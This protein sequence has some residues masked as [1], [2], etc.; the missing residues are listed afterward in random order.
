MCQGD[1]TIITMMFANYSLRPIGNF[2]SP[3][4][5][6]NWPRLLEWVNPNS[7]DLTK[8]GWLMHP[9]YGKAVSLTI[10]LFW[11]VTPKQLS[12]WLTIYFPGPV[13]VDGHLGNGPI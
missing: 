11:L 10:Y 8:E 13:V 12:S 3:H 9:K 1:T 2:T 4:E 5:C 7:R 6:V